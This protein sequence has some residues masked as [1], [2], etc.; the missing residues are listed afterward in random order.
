MLWTAQ[1][2]DEMSLTTIEQ[3]S[4][5][6]NTF[7][8][9]IASQC[10]KKPQHLSSNDIIYLNYSLFHSKVQ[11]NQASLLCPCPCRVRYLQ[12]EQRLH[13]V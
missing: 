9:K 13:R 5:G 3:A 1:T 10:V 8:S 4:D 11:L 2:G 6:Q 7:Q 12:L